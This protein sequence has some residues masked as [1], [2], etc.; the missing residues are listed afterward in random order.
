MVLTCCTTVTL[1]LLS[2]VPLE[3]NA[4]P[5]RGTSKRAAVARG[6]ETP[7]ADY[8]HDA[9][10]PF[11]EQREER[12][13]ATVGTGDFR[14]P[15]LG[16]APYLPSAVVGAGYVLV[17]NWDFGKNGTIRDVSD[18]IAEFEFHDQFNTIANGTNYGA[19]IVAPSA[20]TAIHANGLN[21][22]SGRQPIE[23]PSHPTREWSEDSLKA[24]VRPLSPTQPTVSAAKHD[25]GCGS[26]MA[27]WRLPR[28]GSLLGHDLLW[29]TRV[30][31]PQPKAAYW[32][33]LWTAGN[34]WSAGAEMDVLESFGAPNVYPPA[35]LFHVSSAGG[36]DTI[37]YKSWPNGLE[38]ARIPAHARDLTHW[39]VWSWRYNRDD[40]YQ[41]FLDGHLIQHGMIHWT[42][43][44]QAGGEPI[45]MCFLFDF[46]WGHTKIRAVDITLPAAEFP[47][48][49]EIDYSRVYLR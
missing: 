10:A 36:R 48:T 6:G 38:R 33:A 13:R 43:K 27:K 29:E 18:L 45:D 22:P 31:M 19:V 25:A 21:L 24:H 41:V 14:T 23:D 26:F 34:K 12:T 3:T 40:S 39:H 1:A 20:A 44:G 15:A 9:G 47:L 32:F 4:A 28:A 5:P 7:R 42:R 8:P 11:R 2:M 46:T 17:K 37:S 16:P 35:N 30:R 49:Y